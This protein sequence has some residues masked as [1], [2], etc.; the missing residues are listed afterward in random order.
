VISVLPRCMNAG[1]CSHHDACNKNQ[2]E[3]LS[4]QKLLETDVFFRLLVFAPSCSMHT[5]CFAVHEGPSYVYQHIVTHTHTHSVTP[6]SA[7]PEKA[8]MRSFASYVSYMR[9]RHFMRFVN[10]AP[11]SSEIFIQYE[12]E[13][14]GDDSWLVQVHADLQTA[15]VVF[16]TMSP[17]THPLD[18]PGE[19]VQFLISE[20][21]IAN[22]MLSK[23]LELRVEASAHSESAQCIYSCSMCAWACDSQHQLSEH[24]WARHKVRNPIHAHV[25]DNLCRN[26]G[27]QFHYRIDVI[28]HLLRSLDCYNS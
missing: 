22:N 17:F 19:W 13:V 7:V 18:C 15:A 27:T 25:T 28:R 10:S 14:L 11:H 12:Y 8:C 4:W 21:S 20:S 5:S 26:C 16:G 1:R 3:F 9:L 6:N 24:M 23:L 2:S